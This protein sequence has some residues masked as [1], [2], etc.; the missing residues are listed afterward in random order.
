MKYCFI[1][2]KRDSS[3]WFLVNAI[4]KALVERGEEVFFCYFDD[5]EQCCSS[6]QVPI[7]VKTF[8][9]QV[10]KKRHLWHLYTQHRIFYQE[11]RQLLRR[12]KPH[13]VHTHFAIPSIA[14]RF[15]AHQ[16]NVPM[17]VSTQH[18]LFHSMYPHYRWGLKL[19]EPYANAITYVSGTVAKS[20]GKKPT[21][22]IEEQSKQTP[23]HTVIYNGIDFAEIKLISKKSGKQE[24]HKL[25][26]VGRFVSVK[27]QSVLLQA[28]PKV[29][30]H[31][32]NTKLVLVGAG[33]EESALKKQTEKL[34]IAENV[35]FRGWLSHQET[36]IEMATAEILVVPSDEQEGFGLVVAEGMALGT[37]I[38]ASDIQVFREVL[39][40]DDECGWF[41]KKKNPESL[42]KTICQVFS[43]PEEAITKA[44]KALIRVQERF[45]IERMVGDYLRLYDSLN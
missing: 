3:I 13:L 43:Q 33:T 36:I 12:I 15:I 5:T 10:P 7:G 20:F 40:K 17:I 1:D 38:V 35:Q 41:F 21:R 30:N 24:Q 45:S 29:L 14:A 27:G 44:N 16:E 6:A 9:I 11:F 2:R 22:L 4:A 28:M 8:D 34:A 32:P 26:C 31:F 23:Y 25:I 42:A 39:G 19:T 37:P 18:E